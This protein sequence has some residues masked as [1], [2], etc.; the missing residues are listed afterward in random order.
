VAD[1]RILYGAAEKGILKSGK[2]PRWRKS[3]H[4]NVTQVWAIRILGAAAI[5]AIV[6]AFMLWFEVPSPAAWCLDYEKVYSV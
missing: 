3:Q 1:R 5:I 2:A 4:M 6:H